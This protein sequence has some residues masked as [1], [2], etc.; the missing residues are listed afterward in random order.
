LKTKVAATKGWDDFVTMKV[1]T[2]TIEKAGL[3]TVTIKPLGKP[4][5]GVMNLRFLRLNPMK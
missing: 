4:P 2:L 3:V 5:Q 1:G